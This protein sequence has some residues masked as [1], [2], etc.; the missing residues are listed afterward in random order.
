MQRH[1]RIIYS[2]AITSFLFSYII[3][4]PALS[5]PIY[6]DIV[7]FWYRGFDFLRIPYVEMGFEY[8]PIAGF[9]TYLAAFLGSN[10]LSYYTVFSLII[11]V[12]YLILIE[13]VMRVCAERDVGF[14]YVLIFLCL[15]PSMVLYSVY[16]F[17]LIFA[18]LLVI[19]IYLLERGRLS[20]SALVF[21]LT[22]L[23]KLVNLIALP[24][25]LT[26]IRGLRRQIKYLA[27]SLSLFGAVN[28]ILWMMNPAF[29]DETYLYH[30][31]WGLENAWFLILFPDR[32]S[33]GV[34]KLF[35]ILLLGYG[36]LKIYVLDKVESFNQVFMVLAVFIL[37]SYVFTPQMALWLLPFLAIMGRIPIPYFAFEL[38]NAAIILL[39]FEARDPLK[40]WSPPQLFALL[41]AIMLFMILLE[42]YLGSRRV[43]VDQAAERAS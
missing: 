43:A 38:S 27:I 19:S 7:S 22:A 23:V 32:E 5:N 3:H 12:F 14:E 35:S 6:S 36:L 9:L 18:S 2:A 17:D 16:N 42:V 33:W 30:V 39:W 24:F 15:S 40:P 21:S 25:I 20:F 29:I 13:V 34:A 37:S 8:P 26:H 28:A 41:R 1:R 31:K 4:N 10:I 11:L